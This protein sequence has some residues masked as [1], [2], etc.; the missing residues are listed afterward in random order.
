MFVSNPDALPTVMVSQSHDQY[1][2]G[3]MSEK[4]IANKK[5]IKANK[6]KITHAK[7]MRYLHLYLSRKVIKT[8]PIKAR[9][10]K[11]KATP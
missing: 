7:Y 6:N 9:I 4:T 10:E 1:M 11:P 2:I 8:T 5:P 3:T